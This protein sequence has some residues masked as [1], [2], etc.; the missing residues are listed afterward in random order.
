LPCP[1]TDN[2]GVENRAA[3]G[4]CANAEGNLPWVT[5]GLGRKDAWGNNYLYRVTLAYANSNV[6]FTLTTAKDIQVLNAVGGAAVVTGVPAVI[7]SKGKTGA[8]TGADELENSNANSIFVSHEI[9]DAT[10]A[11]FDDL[12]MWLSPSILASR[13]VSA[14][15]LP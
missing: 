7:V 10:G 6:G 4:A 1:D 8:G 11:E 2:D 5:L 3:N 9:R 15:R 14:G 13:M 12:V